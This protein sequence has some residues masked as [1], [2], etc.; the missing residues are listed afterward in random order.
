MF[1]LRHS[2]KLAKLC[3]RAVTEIAIT[4]VSRLFGLKS[5]SIIRTNHPHSPVY[6]DLADTMLSVLTRKYCIR[7]CKTIKD[8]NVNKDFY[9][10]VAEEAKL[11]PALPFIQLR[12]R[13]LYRH[14]ECLRYLSQVHCGFNDVL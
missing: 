6:S 10:T 7:I 4:V 5:F 12:L 13:F 1:G 2:I 8:N 11:V 9:C 14:I 3:Y